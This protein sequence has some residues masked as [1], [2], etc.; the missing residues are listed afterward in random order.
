M[1]T[2]FNVCPHCQGENIQ[3]YYNISYKEINA[4]VCLNCGYTETAQEKDGE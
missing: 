2:M 4:V 1:L 3:K